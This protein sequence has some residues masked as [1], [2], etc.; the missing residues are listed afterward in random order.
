[1]HS[2]FFLFIG[3]SD[4]EMKDVSDIVD[5]EVFCAELGPQL[6][7]VPATENY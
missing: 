6:L 4:E 3:D 7:H 1:M 2:S 5:V